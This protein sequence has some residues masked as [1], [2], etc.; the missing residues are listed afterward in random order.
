M[1]GPGYELQAR[2]QGNITAAGKHTNRGPRNK[3]RSNQETKKK[4]LGHAQRV[5]K[6]SMGTEAAQNPAQHRRN[7]QHTRRNS[8][9][10]CSVGILHPR[11]TTLPPGNPAAGN[12]CVRHRNAVEIQKNLHSANGGP[13]LARS[14]KSVP[15][16]SASPTRGHGCLPRKNQTFQNLGETDLCTL[17]FVEFPWRPGVGHASPLARDG[18]GLGPRHRPRV[19]SQI[20]EPGAPACV[21]LGPPALSAFGRAG[22]IA[23]NKK[24]NGSL[25]WAC[26]G[27]RP[28]VTRGALVEPTEQ[29]GESTPRPRCLA[30]ALQKP[31]QPQNRSRP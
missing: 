22:D 28:G 23:P 19:R 25:S 13:V 3:Q 17:R 29:R 7:H 9:E 5:Y 30:L 14:S 20:G 11:T 2:I 8:L 15:R 31:P 27:G 26:A 6:T 24:T 4:P 16:K 12:I 10:R 18:D 21:A 1:A